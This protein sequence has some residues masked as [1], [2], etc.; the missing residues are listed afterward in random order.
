MK[1]VS[2]LVAQSN[3]FIQKKAK[4]SKVGAPLQGSEHF[5]TVS[6]VQDPYLQQKNMHGI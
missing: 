1:N 6:I 5:T 4:N 3:S 2:M